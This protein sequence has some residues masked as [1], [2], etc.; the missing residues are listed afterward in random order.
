MSIEYTITKRTYASSNA[1]GK[2]GD[3]QDVGTIQGSGLMSTHELDISAW[4]SKSIALKVYL[5][6]AQT[7]TPE[8]AKIEIEY[9]PIGPLY[10]NISFAVLALQDIELLNGTKEN[11]AG[12]IAATLFSCAESQKRFVIGLPFPEPVGHTKQFQ[13]RIINPGARAPVLSYM[14]P[15]GGVLPT[16]SEISVQLEEL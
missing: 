13:V 5:R 10:Q 8:L 14:D 9:M 15:Q 12:F 3:W 2:I 6:G 4:Q 1:V 11:S 16:S 7:I